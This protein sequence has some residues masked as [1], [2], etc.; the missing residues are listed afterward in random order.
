[1][2]G[3]EEAEKITCIV[4]DL[5]LLLILFYQLVAYV[6]RYKEDRLLLKSF[7]W[8]NFAL[9]FASTIFLI[10]AL[11]R[12]KEWTLALMIT[13]GLITLLAQV[14][15]GFQAYLACN[16]QRLLFLVGVFTVACLTFMSGI[17]CVIVS[18]NSTD[19]YIPTLVYLSLSAG[20]DF[21]LASVFA[22]G[23]FQGKETFDP[24]AYRVMR[25]L[26]VTMNILTL[27]SVLELILYAVFHKNLIAHV[28]STKGYFLLILWPINHRVSSTI[29]DKQNLCDDYKQGKQK[30]SSNSNY[31]N[32]NLSKNSIEVE[33]NRISESSGYVYEPSRQN[34]T[35]SAPASVYHSR[36]KS[37]ATST[38]TMTSSHRLSQVNLEASHAGYWASLDDD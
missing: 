25:I 6:R 9:E 31:K 17:A 11:F 26:I 36:S 1:M 3:E 24:Q 32:K 30:S 34:Q 28:I 13:S 15:L 37:S 20:L 35:I 21:L 7:I 14:F 23:F 29:N 18:A 10:L 16:N 4:C 8:S 2:T 33:P 38:M 22:Y 5:S 27:M 19:D 12:D